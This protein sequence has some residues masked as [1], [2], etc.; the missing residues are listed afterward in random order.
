[1]K[2]FKNFMENKEN[3]ILYIFRGT[4][5]SGKSFAAR[6]LAQETGGVIFSTDDQFGT[7]PEEYRTNISKAIA[8]NK[9]GHYHMLNQIKTIEAMKSGQSPIIIDNT[10]TTKAEILPYFL[11]SKKFGYEVKF[12]E[13]SDAKS[14]WMQLGIPELLKTKDPNELQLAA[15]KLASRSKETHNVPQEAILRM[16]SRFEPEPKPED[17]DDPNLAKRMHPAVKKELGLE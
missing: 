5:S 8:D 9:M 6:K 14:P 3:K 2:T 12:V 1:M 11:A 16:L 7:D 17:F 15:S 10:N 13:P 4:P